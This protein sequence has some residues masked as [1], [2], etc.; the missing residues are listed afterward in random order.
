M[1]FDTL[2]ALADFESDLSFDGDI[3]TDD[4]VTFLLS[5]K[6]RGLITLDYECL[7]VGGRKIVSNPV[8]HQ[9][10]HFLL[11][12]LPQKRTNYTPVSESMIDEAI[13]RARIYSTTGKVLREALDSS[14]SSS[15]S[16]SSLSSSSN[17]SSSL[18]SSCSSSSQ[19]MMEH[20]ESYPAMQITITWIDADETKNFFGETW[21][22]GDTKYLCPDWY[23]GAGGPS[24]STF[25]FYKTPITTAKS[26][27][28]GSMSGAKGSGPPVTINGKF[29]IVIHS[30]KTTA[31]FGFNAYGKVSL[32]GKKWYD[33]SGP[34]PS[35]T[36]T[37]T[38]ARTGSLSTYTPTCLAAAGTYNSPAIGDK[39][40]GQFTTTL[41][42]TVAWERAPSSYWYHPVT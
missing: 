20:C 27:D 22:N 41:G 3:T 40:N 11:N 42:V 29:K 6:E 33:I 15:S 1:I 10:K 4:L 8:V 21:S 38:R 36:R 5:L 39:M 17:S 7:T 37:Y 18:S 35:L 14:S 25:S 9:I 26:G 19:G 13:Y 31:T 24:Y 28:Y 30:T 34:T 2:A 12:T 23:G 32:R 16:S